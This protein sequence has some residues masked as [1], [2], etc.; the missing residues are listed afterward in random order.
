MNI[1][2]AL[3]ITS[4]VLISTNAFAITRVVE[5]ESTSDSSQRLSIV[6]RN[7]NATF[8]TC[9]NVACSTLPNLEPSELGHLY[10]PDPVDEPIH[11]VI[12]EGNSPARSS[13]D[14][15]FGPSVDSPVVVSIDGDSTL[16]RCH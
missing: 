2:L 15:S 3:F 14:L 12:S 7:G 16:Y 1:K 13:V 9:K 11:Y 5:C 6:L 10:M 4:T 8:Y